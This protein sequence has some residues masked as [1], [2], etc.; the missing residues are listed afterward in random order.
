MEP[1]LFLFY[2]K[3]VNTALIYQETVIMSNIITKK[4]LNGN[5]IYHY[6]R[7]QS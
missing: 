1:A 7:N 4:R 5:Y 3:T 6:D 2:R